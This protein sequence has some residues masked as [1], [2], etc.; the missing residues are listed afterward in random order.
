MD[1]SRLFL[2]IAEDETSEISVNGYPASVRCPRVVRLGW[3]EIA[4]IDDVMA[5]SCSQAASRCPAYLTI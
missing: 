3:G 5:F 2:V 1:K 4:A